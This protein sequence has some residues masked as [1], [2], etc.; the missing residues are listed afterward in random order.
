MLSVLYILSCLPEDNVIVC[1]VWLREFVSNIYLLLKGYQT[2][3]LYLI[4]IVSD[5]MVMSIHIDM[6][7]MHIIM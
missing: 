3:M 5:Q 4:V 6:H 2:K 1:W 7:M